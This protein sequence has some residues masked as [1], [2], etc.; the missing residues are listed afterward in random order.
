MHIEMNRR[1]KVFVSDWHSKKYLTK[2]RKMKNLPKQRK[3]GMRSV[4]VCLYVQHGFTITDLPQ[5]LIIWLNQCAVQKQCFVHTLWCSAVHFEYSVIFE[6]DLNTLR[7]LQQPNE[8]RA[9]TQLITILNVVT[10]AMGCFFVSNNNT[11][12]IPVH[13]A[14]MSLIILM[15]MLSISKQ[16]MLKFP[17]QLKRNIVQYLHARRSD[18]NYKC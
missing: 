2:K 14:F 9:S 11:E 15:Q 10:N 6:Y 8:Q 4:Y 12:K 17:L 5:Q 3:H 1:K 7:Q 13:L 18:T 16:Y